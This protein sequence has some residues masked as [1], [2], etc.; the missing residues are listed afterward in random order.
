MFKT[1]ARTKCIWCGLVALGAT[2]VHAQ[3]LTGNVGSA[4]ISSGESAAEVRFGVGEKGDAAARVHYEHAFTDWYQ[5]RVIG[6]FSQPDGEDWGFRALT[7]ENWLQWAEEASDG[8]GF[9]GGVRF[10]YAFADGD[11]SDEFA[12]RL[13]LTDNF[14]DGWEWRA[15]LIGEIQAGNG[16]DGGVAIEARAQLTRSLDLVALNSQDWRLGAELFSEFGNTRDFATFDEQAHQIGPVL[17]VAWENG[18]YLQSAV[19]F[20]LTEGSD[21][22]MVKV[23]LGRE[24]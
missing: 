8:A 6:S 24:F 12:A 4:G 18:V 9:N 20:G 19:R 21:D 23:F 15:N 10:A 17:K 16:S 13:T 14:A 5:L 1:L 11:G 22:A 2:P 7:L 3:S